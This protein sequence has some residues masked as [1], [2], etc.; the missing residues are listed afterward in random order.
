MRSKWGGAWRP[1]SRV[2]VNGTSGLARLLSARVG[3]AFG[4]SLLWLLKKLLTIIAITSACVQ[5]FHQAYTSHF[6]S[7]TNTT[8]FNIFRTRLNIRSSCTNS[9]SVL[10][11]IQHAQ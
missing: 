9:D 4:K 11:L 8:I 3:D 7:I 5:H 10:T 2:S 1:D 6:P